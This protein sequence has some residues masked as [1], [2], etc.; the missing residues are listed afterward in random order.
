MSIL[1]RRRIEALFAKEL[2]THLVPEVGAE[3]AREI[4]RA[5]TTAMAY[6]F[7]ERLAGQT[8]T[9]RP[10]LEPFRRI[11]LPLWQEDDALTIEY[12][13]EGPERLSFNVTR[14]RYAELYRELGV[15][16]L[17]ELLSCTRDGELGRGFNDHIRLTRTQ[18]IMQ[19][20]THCDFRFQLEPG[21]EATG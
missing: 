13:E 16:E 14:C 10:S 19:G 17:G 2:L 9:D 7:G 1:Q 21:A 3:R 4:L 20:A 18:T 6:Q 11:A 12:L 8:G 5:T 15:P